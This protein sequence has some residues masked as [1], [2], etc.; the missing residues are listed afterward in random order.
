MKIS[1][2]KFGMN[3][4]KIFC[5]GMG[6]VTIRVDQSENGVKR[7]LV[8]KK[9]KIKKI[10]N[11]L[12]YQEQAAQSYRKQLELSYPDCDTVMLDLIARS[13]PAMIAHELMFGEH[14]RGKLIGEWIEEES[15]EQK[16]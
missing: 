5:V 13:A 16:T 8:S 6:I 7:N 10:D 9:P 15:G 1:G 14:P 4:G 2:M 3:F 11:P 12:S